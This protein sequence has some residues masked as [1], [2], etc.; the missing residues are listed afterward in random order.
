VTR[1][2]GDMQRHGE[3]G[4]QVKS[5][6][7]TRKAP[8]APVSTAGLQEQLDR[9]A[10]ERDEA[11][12]QQAATSEILQAISSSPGKLEPVFNANATA[13]NLNRL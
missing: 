8:T 12:E 11:L 3:S 10:R 6:P 5:P 13:G 9:R 2:R 7:K 4:Q 1:Q